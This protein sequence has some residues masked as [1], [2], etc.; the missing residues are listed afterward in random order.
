[1]ASTPLARHLKLNSFNLIR[2][3]SLAARIP[4]A[5]TVAPGNCQFTEEWT[6]VKLLKKE[7]VNHDTAL[8]TF[9]TPDTS[10]PLGLSTCACILARSGELIRPYTP[11]ST[12][13]DIGE[14][15]LLVKFY[16]NG[17]NN[18]G[19][20]FSSSMWHMNE[21]ESLD[22]K[23]IP[24]NV[25][26]QYP[27]QCEKISMLVGGTGITPMIQAIHPLLGNVADSTNINLIYGSRT[28]DDILGKEI[29]NEWVARHPDQLS[30][31]H[32][33]SHE[34]PES[35]WRGE[36]GFITKDLLQKYDVLPGNG[37]MVFICGPPPMYDALCGP[38][39]EKELKGTLSEMGFK[40]EEV[41]KF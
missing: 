8:F 6:S 28:E 29:L 10:K 37:H 12:N 19:P 3:Y 20:G 1:M 16:P 32:V 24:F 2:R 4:R 40:S 21:G 41:S 14:F 27:F 35:N 23:H 9:A 31:T 25:K 13:D 39:G 22:F 11:I 38:R 30:V 7:I 5:V 33:L 36:R 34:S 17:S 18:D 15:E 26:I